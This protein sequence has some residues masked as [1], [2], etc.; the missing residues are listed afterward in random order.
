MPMRV[1]P[2]ATSGRAREGDEVSARGPSGG[3]ISNL[4][5]APTRIG[6]KTLPILSE[7]KGGAKREVAASGLP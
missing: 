6:V 3:Q 2:Y 5:E 4:P 1:L 7:S